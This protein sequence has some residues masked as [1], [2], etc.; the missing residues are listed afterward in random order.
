MIFLIKI[1]IKL[2]FVTL[3]NQKQHLKKTGY[4]I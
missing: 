3:G 1:L 2:L 4:M